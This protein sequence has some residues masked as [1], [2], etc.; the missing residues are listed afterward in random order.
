M[1]VNNFTWLSHLAALEMFFGSATMGVMR[2]K[3]IIFT[4]LSVLCFV[5]PLIKV[6]YFKAATEFEFPVIFENLRARNSFVD[7]VDFWF[8]F[9]VAGLLILKL[10]RWT[11]FAFMSVLAYIIYNL[12]TYER[13]TWPYNA[14]SPFMYHYIV[15]MLSVAVFV[16]FLFPQLRRPFFDRRI[17]WWEPEARYNVSI[18]CTIH[19]EFLTYSSEIINISKSGAFLIDTTYF[20]KGERLKMEF[21]FMDQVVS[22][23]IEVKNKHTLKGKDGYGVRFVFRSF[24]ES[25]RMAK[26]IG[27]LRRTKAQQK[28]EP[29]K[30]TKLAA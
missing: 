9:P 23:P 29:K 16:S 30:E 11:Y 2:N 22:I 28:D 14:E 13:Y 1:A 15:A 7:V 24:S 5:E 8:V 12:S 17:R 18:A 10:R 25:L 27:V 21:R 4:I 6:L 19:S 20:R 3:P 26:V